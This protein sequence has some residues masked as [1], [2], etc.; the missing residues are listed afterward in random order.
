VPREQSNLLW[1]EFRRHCNAVFERSAQEAAAYSASLA[2]NAERAAGLIGE[3]GRI[4]TFHDD[5]LREAIKGMDAMREE[6][7]GLD[8]PRQQ[9]RDLR[10][11]F[12]RAVEHC[13]E[14]V[15][16]DRARA[17]NRLW[18]AL[19]EAAGAIRAYA[20]ARAADEPDDRLEVLRAA[21]ETALA[22]LGAA[23]RF[24]RTTLEKRWA[25]VAAGEPSPPDPAANEAALRLLCV[26]AELVTERATPPEDQERR[27]AYQLRRLVESRNLGADAALASLDELALEWLIVGP[28]APATEA[29]LRTRFEQCRGTTGVARDRTPGP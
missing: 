20:W 10:H 7:D 28:V 4:A 25:Q 21:A 2:A 11:R 1:E 6:F 5:A 8:L 3:L 14:A 9:A 16:Q 26:R 12:R 29:A 13:S 22:N 19:F 24:A 17:A 15:L 18:S 27:R 23:P